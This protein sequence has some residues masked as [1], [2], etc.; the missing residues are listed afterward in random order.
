MNREL[1]DL[2]GAFA[3]LE[4]LVVGEAMLDSYLYGNSDRLCREAPVPVVTLSERADLPGGAANTAVNVR[5]LGASVRFLSVIGDDEQGRRLREAL[6][7]KGVDSRDLVATRSRRTL[8]KERVFAAGQM[9]LRVD[10]GTTTAIDSGLEAALIAR[11]NGLASQVDAII[12]SDYGYGVMTPSLI[13]ALGACQAR[14]PRV[15][16]VDAKHPEF[17][18][19]AGPTAVKPNYREALRLLALDACPNVEQRTQ[20]MLQ[21]ESDLLG[22]TGAQIAAVTLDVEGA[23]VLERGAPMYRT[24]ARPRPDSHATGA[25]DTFTSALCLALAAGAPTPQAAELASAA[26]AVVVGKGATTTCSAQEL[27]GH[28]SSADKVM[29][30]GDELAACVEFLRQQG[31]RIV[32]TNGCF[33][34][35]HR[36]HIT[37]LN[38]AKALGDVLIVGVNS[39]GSVRRLKGEARPINPLEDRLGV[40]AGLSCVDHLI[41]F[42]EDT[43]VRVIRAVRPDVFVKGGDYRRSDLPEADLVEELGG[44]I[45]ILPFLDAHSTT[46][47]I[48]RVRE[49]FAPPD[50][51]PRPATRPGGLG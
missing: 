46:S 3:G 9:A 48:E 40:L 28:L 26:A 50:D 24:Y 5:S 14:S 36:G 39:D 42:D 22:R 34:I 18:R 44:Q 45:R 21:R 23:V 41:P 1:Y 8:V 35:L 47:I 6:E 29:T 27:C 20:Q 12:V 51:A 4:V 43:P 33:D 19:E 11:L 30:G 2:I 32:F 17:Y 7:D 25:G 13:A 10:D 38:R 49:R 15:L 37:Y 31:K 16:V